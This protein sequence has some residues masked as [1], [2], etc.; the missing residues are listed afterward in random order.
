MTDKVQKIRK[1]V[2]KRYE[3]WKEKEFNSHSIESETRMS[4]CKH[5]LLMLDSLQEEPVS[6]WHNMD[7]EKPSHGSDVCLLWPRDSIITIGEWE[8]LE[9]TSYVSKWAYSSDL[10]D[11]KK[12]PVSEELEEA[13]NEYAPDFSNSI[14]SKATV[15]AVRDAFKAGAKWQKKQIINK[16]CEYLDG[17]IELLNDHGH[18]L[19][20]ERIIGGLKQAIKDE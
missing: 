19:K 2:K 8:G 14:A 9:N 12:E 10:L 5:L 4:E 15:D 18:G 16:A 7:E 17:L 3:Y 6:V 13:A 11:I 20:K 1:A